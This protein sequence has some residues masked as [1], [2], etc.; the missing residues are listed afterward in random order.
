MPPDRPTPAET[1][2]TEAADGS[3]I[4][5]DGLF[6]QQR[7][8]YL[9]PVTLH[10]KR[11]LSH[12]LPGAALGIGIL[13]ATAF[14]AGAG[15][16]CY[17][18]SECGGGVCRNGQCTTAGARCYS[19]DECAGGVCRGGQCTTAGARCYS[20]DECAGGKCRGGQCTTGG[21]RCYSDDECAG[22]K[23][24]SGLCTTGG[25][26]CYADAECPGGK[27]RDGQCT[28]GGAPAATPHR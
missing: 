27:C 1:Q 9:L 10:L 21:G 12:M 16:R 22:G 17:A 6:R 19:D 7:S 15:G 2:Q 5:Q 25:G 24:R 8:R 14:A 13:L 28:T 3:E 20:D 18:D 11:S 23:C 26:R 4:R